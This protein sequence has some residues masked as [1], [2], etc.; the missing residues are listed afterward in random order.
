MDNPDPALTPGN[1]DPAVAV[2]TPPVQA[3][4]A[5]AWKTQLSAD[6]AGAPS[7]QKFPDTKEGFNEA[8]KSHLLLEKL[9]GY[10]KVPIPKSKDD[11]AARAIFNKAMGIPDK[12]DGYNLPDV[13]VPDTMKGLSFDKAK[14]A[15]TVHKFDLTPAAAKGLWESYTEMNKQ[16]YAGALKAQQEKMTGVINQMRSEWGDAYQSKVELGQM[17]INKFS[18][19]Q[20]MNDY[21]TSVLS[22]DPRGIKFLAKIGDQ[23]SE[24]KIGDFK[25]GRHALTPEEAQK[26][27]DSIRSDANHPYN[28][29]KSPQAERDRAISYVNSLIAVSKPKGQA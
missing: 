5:F 16:A 21:I 7:M 10:E 9:L 1:P 22:S 19:D 14:F 11:H 17:V 24:N 15:E 26:E 6:L 4:Q 13:S 27:L 2:E 29:D 25:Y 23:F 3:P 8:V 20:E 28:N 18:A 12:P